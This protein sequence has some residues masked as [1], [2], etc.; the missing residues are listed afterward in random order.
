MSHVLIRHK[1]GNY[2]KWKRAVQSCAGWRK[3]SG[4]QSFQVFRMS[5]APNDLTI[6]C[7][8]SSAA[9]ARKFMTS[10]ELRQRVRDVLGQRIEQH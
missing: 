10:A 6:L 5:S 4:E 3:A 8:W 9:Q 1:V 7:R 2:A